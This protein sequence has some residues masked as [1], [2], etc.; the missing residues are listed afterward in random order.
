MTHLKDVRS[1]K[2]SF[3]LPA[4]LSIVKQSATSTVVKDM[5]PG[6]SPWN[7]IG[8]VIT[9]LIEESTKLVQPISEPENVVK[10]ELNASHL[11]SCGRLTCIIFFPQV[12]GTPPWVTRIAEVKAALAVNIEAER[13]LASLTDEMQAMARTLRTKEQT[14]QESTVKIQLMERRLETVRKQAD[15]IVEL[16]NELA[17]ARKQERTYEE[18]MEQL[19]SDLD[20]LE[21]DNSKL[22]A[23]TAG[24]ERQ[25]MFILLFF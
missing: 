5:K 20:A 10:S 6:A 9:N 12:T 22:K 11:I 13:K 14:I 17:K 25:G 4:I 1:S 23:L 16:E 3:H 7:A 8:S 21:Q 18:A 24:Q 2:S 15:A 19:H